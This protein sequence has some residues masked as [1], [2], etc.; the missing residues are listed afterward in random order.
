MKWL[1]RVFRK[2]SYLSTYHALNFPY[3][4]DCFTTDD[5]TTHLSER[6]FK[7][8]LCFHHR[9]GSGLTRENRHRMFCWPVAVDP[10]DGTAAPRQEG[11]D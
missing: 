7:N 2:S 1:S 9:T 10:V 5:T 4:C 3:N 8:S 6:H 11:S